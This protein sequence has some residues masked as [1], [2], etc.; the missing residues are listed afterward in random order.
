MR[1]VDIHS[2]KAIAHVGGGGQH[3]LGAATMVV[4]NFPRATVPPWVGAT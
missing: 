1:D 3:L 2:P 4:A